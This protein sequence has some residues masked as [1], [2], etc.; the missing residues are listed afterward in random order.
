MDNIRGLFPGV[1]TMGNLF[2]GF[3][4]II[5]SVNRQDP[6]EAAWLILL[7]VFLDMMDGWVARL[8]GSVTRFGVELDSLADLVSFGVAPA[9]LLYVN[10]LS[11]LGNW[12]WILGFIYI[13]AAA[14]RLARF[15]LQSDREKSR[16][17]MGLP[18]PAAAVALAGYVIFSIHVW[19]DVR[20][21]EVII[22]LM[23]GSS[24]L[25]VSTIRYDSNVSFSFR[26]GENAL[27]FTLFLL[28]ALAIAFRPRIAIFGVAVLYILYGLIR[29]GI[30]L[31]A[32]RKKTAP[33]SDHAQ[34]HSGNNS[35][36]NN[37][38]ISGEDFTDGKSLRFP[39]TGR[40][41]SSG[42]DH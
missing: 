24:L 37:N 39:E 21:N 29:E 25:M 2:C 17:F 18:A 34:H 40:R 12:G 22:M 38:R 6:S 14:F 9:V 7:A 27:Q 23:I 15:N 41:R 28:S 3:L 8:S 20:F 16:Y 10:P 11:S 4:A 30:S 26:G 42:E 32:Q 13:I 31:T 36:N 5:S 35:I 1:F 19:G 33:D